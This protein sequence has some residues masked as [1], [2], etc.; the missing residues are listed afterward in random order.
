MK[1]VRKM[2][3]DYVVVG[4][5]PGGATVARELSVLGKRVI[6]LERGADHQFY[7]NL[8]GCA[9]MLERLGFTWTVEGHSMLR[10]L[11]TGGSSMIYG[12]AAIDPPKW[13]K[14][15]HDIDLAPYVTA[16]KNELRI[17]PT[18][19][20]MIGPRAKMIMKAAHDL[21][22]PWEPMN[23]FIDHDR[24]D[25]KC[26]EC[27]Y[28]CKKEGVKWTARDYAY[29]AVRNGATL[30]N[31]A[32]VRKV[33]ITNGKALGVIADT[34]GG[35]LDVTSK[36]TVI[37]AGGLGTPT[38]LL[39]SGLTEAGDRLFADPLIITY[40]TVGKDVPDS[41]K[42]P[43]MLCGKLDNADGLLIGDL[44]EP[45]PMFILQMFYKGIGKMRHA[46]DFSRRL[47]V[48]VKVRD[49]MEG[50]VRADETCSKHYT[51][52]DLEKME[53]GIEISRQILLKAGCDPRSIVSTPPRAAHPGSTARIGKIVD[54]D[55]ETKIKNLYVCDASVLPESCGIPPVLT[56]LAFGKRLV[57]ERL[58]HVV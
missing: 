49:E 31:K 1:P 44:P 45:L 36:V 38:I 56:I 40:G 35:R 16:L 46:L 4:S 21:D 48:M 7:G 25:Q 3:A 30:I 19:D 11:T 15:N 34:P 18:P 42:E 23:K 22:I 13:L 2:S 58:K 24:C 26:P 10:A 50:Y 55:L 33:K 39:R 43:P 9:F 52:P 17:K 5:G 47:A 6:L 51:L 57:G 29:E 20:H 32:T 28:G 53:R 37:S 27:L 14:Q 41:P 12:A 54:R 8:V